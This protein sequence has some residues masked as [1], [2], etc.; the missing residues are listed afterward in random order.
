MRTRIGPTKSVPKAVV[1]SF[2][3]EA[4]ARLAPITLGIHRKMNFVR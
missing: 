2:E 1:Y 3:A 4:F